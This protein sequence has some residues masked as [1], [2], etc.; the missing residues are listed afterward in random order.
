MITLTVQYPHPW[1]SYMCDLL[2]KFQPRSTALGL[3]EK[4][5]YLRLVR[6]LTIPSADFILA[7]IGHGPLSDSGEK[8]SRRA[9]A[10]SQLDLNAS[11]HHKRLVR[12]SQATASHIS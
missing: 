5:V 12:P 3:T 8:A 4:R 7:I 11:P 2:R 10:W 9:F 1:S 6:S